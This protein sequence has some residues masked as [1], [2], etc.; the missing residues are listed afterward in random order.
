MAFKKKQN[1]KDIRNTVDTSSVAV[2]AAVAAARSGSSCGCGVPR[3][4]CSEK[5]VRKFYKPPDVFTSSV[6]KLQLLSRYETHR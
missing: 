4:I 5:H 6:L 3:G 1:V 2:G